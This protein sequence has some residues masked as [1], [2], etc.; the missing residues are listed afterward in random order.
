[1][2][3]NLDI[4]LRWL[5]LPDVEGGYVNDPV[6]RGGET[7]Y[8]ICARSYPDLD[9]KNLTEEQAREIYRRDYWDANNLDAFHSPLCL[10]LFDALVQHQP[11]TAISL[12][13]RA[14]RVPGD[15]LIGP[16]TIKAAQRA[17]LR[18]GGF[19]AITNALALRAQL[20]AGLV[21]ANSSQARFL[22]GWLRRLFLLQSF[23]YANAIGFVTEP[24][25]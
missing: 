18:D 3:T 10:I 1:M 4:A 15:G 16:V 9:I 7:K 21:T 5:W 2:T 14:L 24:K 23:I 8:G 11:R 6:D 13:Q 25:P 12:L 20:Y 22:Y 19:D 17:V